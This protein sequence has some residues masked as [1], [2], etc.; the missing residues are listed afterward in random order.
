M[1]GTGRGEVESASA[2]D[3]CRRGALGHLHRAEYSGG[4]CP[5]V[6]RRHGGPV[7]GRSAFK[8]MK[9]L[10]MTPRRAFMDIA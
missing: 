8:K 7:Y 9:A 6:R 10:S 4:N 5:T 1:G 2:T 3:R